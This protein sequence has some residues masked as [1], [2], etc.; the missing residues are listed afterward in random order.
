MQVF[1]ARRV[2]SRSL[3]QRYGR[4][5]GRLAMDGGYS[6]G[7]PVPSESH[8]RS[9]SHRAWQRQQQRVE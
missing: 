1:E 8:V 2:L 7:R 9:K 3:V 5:R 6:G 4:A